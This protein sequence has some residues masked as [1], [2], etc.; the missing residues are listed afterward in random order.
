[1]PWRYSGSGTSRAGLLRAEKWAWFCV[2][3]DTQPT[4]L[5]I[6]IQKT[7]QSIKNALARSHFSCGRFSFLLRLHSYK[8]RVISLIILYPPFLVSKD[9]SYFFLWRLTKAFM[10][11]IYLLTEDALT[12]IC[13][14]NTLIPP[15]MCLCFFLQAMRLRAWESGRRP[16]FKRP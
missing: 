11:R 13:T 15:L 2:C 7:C 5:K 6:F 9:C 3:F 10:K 16:A 12:F 1:M 14:K 8:A 4:P